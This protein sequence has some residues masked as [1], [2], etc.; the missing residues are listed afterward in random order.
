MSATSENLTHEDAAGES[1]ARESSEPADAVQPSAA[2]HHTAFGRAR[3]ALR[4]L[5]RDRA[6][7][8]SLLAFVLTRLVVFSMFVLTAQLS[9][10]RTDPQT[11]L[12]AGVIDLRGTQFASLMRQRVTR[13]DSNW[14]MSIAEYGYERRPFSTERHANW[15]FFPL[16]PLALRVLDKPI[17]DLPLTGVAFSTL[18]FLFALP[19]LHKTVTAL[20]FG[21]GDA[22][23]TV[24]YVAAFPVS[25]FFSLPMTESLF[26]LLTVGAF[27]AAK[28]EQWLVAG[29]LGALAS[30]T[31]VTGVLLLPAL[32]LLY[33]ETYRTFRPR[34]NAL[35]LL[36][37]PAGLVSFMLF[38]HRITGNA[39]AF[40]DITVAAWGRRPALFVVP[41]LSYLSKPLVIAE[42]WDFRLLNFT[43]AAVALVCGVVLLKWRRW[44]LAAYTLLSTIIALSNTLLH[45]QAR[46][47]MALF[48]VFIVLAVVGR[49]A[50]F[51]RAL[52]TFM[53]ILLTLMTA[54]FSLY[55]DIA[56]A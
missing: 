45:S 40:R 33:W 42:S 49:N 19:L 37:I 29:L 6:M 44:S 39:L 30:A 11:G 26:L 52:S 20:G 13:G 2:A 35:P 5:A 48:P 46:Y 10:V 16:F 18:C 50:R 21:A 12:S 47:A 43:G 4:R 27:Y 14:Y 24:F 7:R 56:L 9:V 28:R 17:G 38:L 23:R 54:L 25:Y 34:L 31:R 3:S 8:A 36:L 55:V 53:L 1:A 22:D 15:A 51:D 32:A 41:L